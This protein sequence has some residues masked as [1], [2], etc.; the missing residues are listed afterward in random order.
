[1]RAHYFDFS[2]VFGS[3]LELVKMPWDAFRAGNT[4]LS[5]PLKLETLQVAELFYVFWGCFSF[6]RLRNEGRLSGAR[7]WAVWKPWSMRNG[8]RSDRVYEHPFSVHTVMFCMTSLLRP[9]KTLGDGNLVFHCDFG[10]RQ[11]SFASFQD[12]LSDAN[13]ESNAQV[14]KDNPGKHAFGDKRS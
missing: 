5:W 3:S 11:P 4:S 8:D 14:K 6:G 10:T 2:I 1:M 12:S 9:R 13:A 7:G